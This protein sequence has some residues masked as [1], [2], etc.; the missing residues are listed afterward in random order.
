MPRAAA[1]GGIDSR[2]MALTF[3]KHE[4]GPR[5]NEST[6]TSFI[7]NGP[8]MVDFVEKHS[9]VRFA[10]LGGFP[11]YHC[12]SPGGSQT[13]RAYYPLNWDAGPLGKEIHRLRQQNRFSMFFG[14]QIGVNE[15]GYYMTAGRKFGSLVYVAKCMLLRIRDQFRA[16]RTLRLG[17]GNALVGGLASAAFEK[18][19]RLW[20]S[21]P[22]RQLLREGGRV[23]GAIVDTAHGPVRVEASRGVV[24]ATG[25][26][27]HDS[28]RRA[29][30]FPAG[31]TAPEVWG[32]MPYGN[33]GD[34]IRL[35]EAVGAHFNDKMKSPIALTPINTLRPGEGV[36]ETMPIFFN[37]GLPGV[38]AVTRDGKRFAN[39]GRSYH[40]VGVKLLEKEAGRP[41]AVAWIICDHRVLRRSGMGRSYPFPLP[42]R[43]FIRSGYLKA[44]RTIRELAANAG[45][46]ADALEDTVSS[47]NQNA[48]K[49]VDPEF[50]RGSNA[51]DRAGGDP[52]HGP[53]PCVGPL[54]HAP[55]YAI[56]IYAGCVGTFCG[57][58]T[59]GNAVVLDAAGQE[60]SGLY[61]AGNDMASVT[62]GDYISG[63]CT[64]GPGMT[65]GYMAGRHAA[66]V[67]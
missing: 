61:A 56:R 63:G 7:D 57:L 30:L 50:G 16:G 37:R 19:L 31:A 54:K 15:V 12:D 64:L 6:V 18:G 20:T 41:Q 39:E 46:D 1:S 36:L 25:G 60:I 67:K 59:N 40:D 66:G 47:Y 34:G 14:M 55:F 11:D 33:S 28:K 9:P 2:E 4:T 35:G 22:A 53:N 48:E 32:M 52:A 26:F 58:Q 17:A 13:G 43:T 8:A 10:W 21:A 3:F 45:I 5:F 38:I 62:G 49:G 42:Y 29:E 27:P 24:L 51:F 65:F 44:G 23:T